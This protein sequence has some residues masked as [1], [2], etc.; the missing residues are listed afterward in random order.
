[1]AAII[2]DNFRR[3]S[4]AFLINDIKDQKTEFDSPF[5]VGFEYFIG[6][7]KSDS[8]D[9]DA[10]GR[11]EG[12]QNFSTPL[13][14]GSVIETKTVL[15]NLIGAIGIKGENAYYVIPRNNWSANRRY[16][17]WNEND[18]TMFDVETVG[19]NTYYP[20][21]T[22]AN[23]RIYICLDNDSADSYQS[24]TVGSSSYVPGPSDTSPPTDGSSASATN[25]EA[26]TPGNDGYT[27]VYIADIDTN[28]E[29]NTD[30]FVSISPT[31]TGTAAD[32]T[33]ATGGLVY[34]FEIL[35]PGSGITGNVTADFRLVYSD[36]TTPGAGPSTEE[37]TATLSGGVLT[38]I[39]F[40]D[41]TAEIKAERATVVYSGASTVAPIIR[42]LV[43]PKLGF[44]HTPTNDLP[45]FYAGLTVDYNGD[46]NGELPTSISYR[47]ISLLRDPTRFDDDSINTSTGDGSYDDNEVFNAL[48]R[49]EFGNTVS[50]SSINQGD[51]IEDSSDDLPT[52]TVAAKA[53]VDYVDDTNKYVYF[54]QNESS[55]INQQDFRI[56]NGTN[57][58]VIIKTDADSPVNTLGITAYTANSLTGTNAKPEYTPRT[59]EVLFL[60][61]RKPIQRAASQEEEIKLVIQF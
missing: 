8:W 32:A 61:N 7:G 12:N 46:V 16:K 59:G 60:E 3:N 45:S 36:T 56:G 14:D 43:A 4:T 11:E 29:F 33:T 42:P 51:I 26:K 49:F 23:D 34:G 31:A 5:D 38:R 58:K 21:Y 6:I 44:G 13:P 48:R 19:G 20:C 39:A 53:F 22:I 24:G 28:S 9:A 2:T 57:S 40:T 35:N 37:L 10:N 1:M 17:R 30:Q 55:K 18:P 47:Q 54:H 15:D 41:S 52:G 25:R 27:W 50:L